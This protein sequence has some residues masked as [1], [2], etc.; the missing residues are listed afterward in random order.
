V[1]SAITFAAGALVQ[2]LAV[3]GDQY[4]LTGDAVAFEVGL[5]LGVEL[6]REAGGEV[7]R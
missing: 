5:Q 7:T 3:V 6:G 1:R 4:R 2:H